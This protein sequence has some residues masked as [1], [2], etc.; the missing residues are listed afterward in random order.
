MPRIK[1]CRI[2][3]REIFRRIIYN[4]FGLRFRISHQTLFCWAALRCVRRECVMGDG[5]KKTRR[6]DA[7][8]Y[9]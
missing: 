6:I 2:P 3:L 8:D 7:E 4:T 1:L 5:N 9:I